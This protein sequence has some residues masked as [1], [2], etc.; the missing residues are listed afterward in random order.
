MMS[1]ILCTVTFVA[2][3]ELED[4][5]GLLGPVVV[6]PHQVRDEAARLAQ[7]LGVG[8]T[9]VGPPELRLGPLSVFDVGVDPVPLDDGAGLVAQRVRT[10]EKPAI[11]AV[12]PAQSRFGLSRRFRSH[13]A[14]PRRRQTVHILRVDG[15]RPAPTARLFRRK[16]DEVQIVLVEE[17]GAS[18]G[19]RRPGQRRNRVDDELEIA[20]ARR[21]GLLGAL[22]LVDVDEQVVPADDVPVRIAKRKSAR[23][24]PA[25]DA[26][27]RRARYFELE[28]VTGRDRMR[29]DL[30]DARKILRMNR[31]VGPPVLQLLQR[32]AE[33]LEDL[34]VDEFDLTGR[35]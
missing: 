5:V 20:L 13:D 16:A 32:L 12:V 3:I 29:E 17:L 6:V 35:A 1:R 9:V 2:G 23:L 34:A 18:I 33:V 26:I 10:E 7:P 30:D 19:P 14:L 15:S 25:V 11:L 22:A 24:K 31:A 27:E 8:E 4:A 21:E 28:G